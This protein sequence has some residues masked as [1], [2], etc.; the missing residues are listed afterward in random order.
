MLLLLLQSLV[1]EKVV[2]EDIATCVMGVKSRGKRAS[3]V[4]DG[5]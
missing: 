4:G 3:V 5:G 1:V 2:V